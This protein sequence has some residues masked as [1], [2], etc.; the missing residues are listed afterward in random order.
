MLQNRI[1]YQQPDFEVMFN[2]QKLVLS[3]RP[4]MFSAEDTGKLH[5]K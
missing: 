3:N 5:R 4:D 1:H 2:D